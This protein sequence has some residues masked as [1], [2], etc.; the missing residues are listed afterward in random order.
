MTTW[1]QLPA[2]IRDRVLYFFTLRIVNEYTQLAVDPWNE[3]NLEDINDEYEYY[4]PVICLQHFSWALRTSR[5]FYNALNCSIIDG[6]TPV[7]ILKHL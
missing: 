7:Q 1:E 3:R 4:Y 2:E 5:Y 6:E